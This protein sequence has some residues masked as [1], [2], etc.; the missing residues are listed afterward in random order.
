MNIFNQNID[1]PLNEEQIRILAKISNDNKDV[2]VLMYSQ[3]NNIKHIDEIFINDVCIILLKSHQY[4]GHWIVI[5]RKNKIIEYYDSYG[6]IINFPLIH[7]NTKKKNTELQQCPKTLYILFKNSDYTIHYNEFQHQN[8]DTSTCGRWCC[9][10]IYFK[11][12]DTYNFN[13]YFGQISDPEGIIIFTNKIY[14]SRK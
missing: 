3:L 5:L 9:F 13:K 10:R 1:T 2:N 6:Q 12:L 11:M 8:I 7:I 4:Y 14:N